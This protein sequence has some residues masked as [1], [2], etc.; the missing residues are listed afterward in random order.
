MS[1][2]N[3]IE[4]LVRQGKSINT[5]KSYRN[6]IDDYYNWFNDSFGSEPDKLYRENILDYK[7]YLT[8]IRKNNGKTI[9][10][11]LSTLI[12]Y[13]E[14][15][16][17]N[18]IQN[19]YVITKND[20][21]KIQIQITNPTNVTKKEV[22]TF[23]QLILE[24]EGPRNY[25]IVTIMAY[26][27]LRISEV[28]NLKIDDVNITAK[29]IVVYNGKGNKQRIVYINDKIVNAVTEYK[30]KRN[31]ISKK[32]CSSEYLFISKESEKLD[33]TVVNKMF[34]KYSD[35]I[36][37]HTLRHF[38]CTNALESGYSLHEV[39]NQAGHSNIA[40][41]MIYTNPTIEKMKEKANRL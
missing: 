6:H 3:F 24:H 36:T 37:P 5:I 16:I 34:N 40:T 38:Y 2:D 35:K 12:K 18:G 23:R 19:D 8:N 29:E 20:Y 22:E 9:N 39:A 13:N 32:Y 27:G 30:K 25:A 28:L 41:T 21:I 14:Y 7:S 15:L 1:I 17:F 26:A 31:N 33:R 4:Y 10:A 11:K